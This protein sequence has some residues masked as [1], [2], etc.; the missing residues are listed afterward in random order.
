MKKR[1][2]YIG[3]DIGGANTKYCILNNNAIDCKI[4]YCELWRTTKEIK[5]LINEIHKKFSNKYNIINA[6]SMSG[7]M[8][9]IFSTR[10]LGVKKILSF[11]DKQKSD[12]YVFLKNKKFIKINRKVSFD[13]IA[14]M[15]WLAVATYLKSFNQNI[16]GIDLGSTTTD[17]LLIKNNKILNKRK[18]DFTGL[19][20][21]ELIYT[22]C[23]RTPISAI[24]H[25]IE[26][27]NKFYNIIPENFAS[28]ADIYNVL[29]VIPYKHNYIKSSDNRPK[30]SY[31]AMKRLARIFGFDYSK[32]YKNQI[33]SL[34]KKIMSIHLD[35][36]SYI[37]N[38]HINDKYSTIKDLKIIGIGVGRELVRRVCKKNKWNYLDFINYI[39]IKKKKGT[40]SASDVAPAFALS[41][42]IKNEYD[43]TK[44]NRL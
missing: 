5:K 36:I 18:N 33:L 19:T 24:T 40:T 21:S 32:S 22:G 42:L 41:N 23:L 7:E 1:N 15:N 28:M 39:D 9:D 30:T 34:S 25:K 44:K 8:C 12:S 27:R 20:S 4:K 2:I 43:E 10:E 3:W 31:Y 26:M 35:Q 17:I 14:S 16:I 6:I 13:L 38:Y 37:I 29:S 11:F